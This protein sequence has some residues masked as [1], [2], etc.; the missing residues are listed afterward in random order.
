MSSSTKSALTC[1]AE[2]IHHSSNQLL[3]GLQ[4]HLQGDWSLSTHA[5]R[6]HFQLQ[7]PSSEIHSLLDPGNF[8]NHNSE[9]IIILGVFGRAGRNY[10]TRPSDLV[11]QPF[12]K[13]SSRV[14][15]AKAV[16]HP[17]ADKLLDIELVIGFQLRSVSSQHEEGVPLQQLSLLYGVHTL[18]FDQPSVSALYGKIRMRPQ[19]LLLCIYL[20][21]SFV[22]QV[23]CLAKVLS[24]RRMQGLAVLPGTLRHGRLRITGLP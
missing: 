21:A 2:N 7:E 18:H 9:V 10:L 23:A 11:C 14:S 3:A 19:C 20:D 22:S 5:F 13:R 24:N 1:A 4:H 8:W 17:H 12:K 15:A 16:A 6:A